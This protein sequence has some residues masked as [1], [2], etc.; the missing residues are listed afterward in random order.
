MRGLRL[1][2][3]CYWGFSSVVWRC[4]PGF[5][6]HRDVSKECCAFETFV[7]T[8][9]ATHRHS[10]EDVDE[11]SLF[12]IKI[13]YLYQPKHSVY[14]LHIFIL[15][16][17]HV[18]VSQAVTIITENIWALYLKHGIIMKLL[19]IHINIWFQ[20]KGRNFLPENSECDTETCIE[21]IQ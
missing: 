14:S 11:Y 4:V 10:L 12:L 19:T 16:I 1:S 7:T 17:L 21:E 18:S 15:F 6:V 2:Q 3:Q 8:N 5:V 20:V 13:I 9:P